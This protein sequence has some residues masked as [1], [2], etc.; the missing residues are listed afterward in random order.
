MAQVQEIM[1]KGPEQR[2]AKQDSET[3]TYITGY[4]TQTFTSIV[5]KD[6]IVSN[7]TSENRL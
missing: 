7:I 1:G 4:S 6:G 3:W 2:D 5:F